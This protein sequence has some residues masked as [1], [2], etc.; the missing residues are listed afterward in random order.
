MLTR[1][2]PAIAA[3]CLM[4]LLPAGA[5]ALGHAQQFLLYDEVEDAESPGPLPGW[6]VLDHNNDGTT[7]DTSNYGGL[8]NG[9]AWRLRTNPI[10][11]TDD[12]L[13]TIP[14]LL[15]PEKPLLLT[16]H[17]Y[18]AHFPV[19]GSRLTVR[20]GGEPLEKGNEFPVTLLVIEPLPL[21][22]YQ[23]FT[24]PFEVDELGEYWIEFH[25][26][27]DPETGDPPFPANTIWLAGIRFSQPEEVLEAGLQLNRAHFD[28]RREP[29]YRPGDRIGVMVYVRNNGAEP[30]V[31]N[32][33]MALDDAEHRLGN[34]HFLITDSDGREV[35][36][37]GGPRETR[38]RGAEK[39]L[40]L[41]V[42]ET[43]A[44][45]RRAPPSRE[46][47]VEVQ[48]GEAIYEFFDLGAGL[49][50][51]SQ[52]GRYTV[53]ARYRNVFAPGDLGTWRGSVPT[54]EISFNY[55]TIETKEEAP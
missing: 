34:I 53:Q 37:G 17:L 36:L 24:V 45:L 13:R 30:V 6:S 27:A 32:R 3:G 20:L 14:F 46:D 10:Q 12:E 39:P 29:V 41:Q 7:W 15:Q 8:H 25:A 51:F 2:I 35:P 16:F 52:E 11:G 43:Y 21:G 55:S 18:L 33:R 50:S 26:E 48:P 31:L 23:E 19:Q 28:P 9:K 1:L 38:E 22:F 42:P 44:L 4:L 54:E 47:F 5:S 49:Y 40:I